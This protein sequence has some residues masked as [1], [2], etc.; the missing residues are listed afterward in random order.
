MKHALEACQ[1]NTLKPKD[2]QTSLRKLAKLHGVNKDTLSRRLAGNASIHEFNAT[3]Q[4]LTPKEERVLLDH[5]LACS[6]RG[7][8]MTHSATISHAN[9]ILKSRGG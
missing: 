2:K 9:Q 1:H 3:K 5:L 7:F 4:K 6:D 8:P